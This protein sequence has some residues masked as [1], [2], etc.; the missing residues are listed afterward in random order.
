MSTTG[1][2]LYVAMGMGPPPPPA[3]QQANPGS[4]VAFGDTSHSGA[5]GTNGHGGPG[6][7][8][9]TGNGK[10]RHI[11][12]RVKPRHAVAGRRTAFRFRAYIGSKP[13]AGVVI[14]FAG[15]RARTKKN[16]RARIVARLHRGRHRARGTK[17]G[18]TRGS[19]RVYVRRR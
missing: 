12:L 17:A 5:P 16:G 10:R 14:R 3:P 8:G 18:M 13:T 2:A 1:R 19:V 11:R 9:G 6:P 4:I 15:H 7:G